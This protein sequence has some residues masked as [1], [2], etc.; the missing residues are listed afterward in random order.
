MSGKSESRGACL[1]AETSSDSP[2]PS[3]SGRREGG[4]KRDVD[5]S[6]LALLDFKDES[7][8]LSLSPTSLLSWAIAS[9]GGGADL[10]VLGLV[11]PSVVASRPF[12]HKLVG[13]S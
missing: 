4:I 5:G 12:F 11:L 2:L 13:E 9:R 10:A 1:L 6:V 8:D 7:S 3:T